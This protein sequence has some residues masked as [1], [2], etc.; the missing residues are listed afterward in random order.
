[1]VNDREFGGFDGSL[2]RFVDDG[3]KKLEL[4]F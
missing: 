1:M 2:G 3:Q 4:F